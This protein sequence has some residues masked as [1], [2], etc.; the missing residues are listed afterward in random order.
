MSFGDVLFRGRRFI[1]ELA[2]DAVANLGS[3]GAFIITPFFLILVVI[4]SFFVLFPLGII[5]LLKII[6]AEQET[7]QSRGRLAARIVASLQ[8]IRYRLSSAVGNFV[9]GMLERT[10]QSNGGHLAFLFGW[11][12]LLPSLF[13]LLFLFTVFFIPFLVFIYLVSP[14]FTAAFGIVTTSPGASYVPSFYAP[15]TKSSRWSR[16]VFAPFGFIFGGLHCI[17]WYFVYPT[18]PEHILWRTT[19]LAIT[20]IPLVV[21]PID[22]LL[23]TRLQNRDIKSCRGFE[24]IALIC[25]DL[26]MTILL[27]TY[28]LARLSIFTQA[29]ALLRDQPPS[30]FLVVDWT[31]YVPHLFS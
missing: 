12:V 23:S 4:F 21:A 15:I 16:V 31:K 26:I 30:S 9:G 29:F 22:F 19:S 7:S 5:L 24:R 20:F 18:R 13:L 6:K 28:V 17:G 3:I 25:L 10:F 1:K 27:F 2:T 11:F 8:W 14:V